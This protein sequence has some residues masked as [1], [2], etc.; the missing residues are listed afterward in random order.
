MAIGSSYEFWLADDA[1]A[2]LEFLEPRSWE[3]AL[4]VNGFGWFALTL[5]SS[6]DALLAPDYRVAIWRRPPG[7]TLGLEMVGLIR[8][9]DLQG[10]DNDE[11]TRVSGPDISELLDR[12][13]VAY[14]AASPQSDKTDFA[15]DMM[16]EVVGQN[17]GAGAIAARDIT[18]LGF[19]IAG[20]LGLGPSI[21]K[22]F[23]WRN[24]LR[25]L[26]DI[27]AA[28]KS[29]G[30]EVF[31]AI[32]PTTETMFQ[33]QTFTGQ[34]GA[35]RTQGGSGNPLTISEE[36][37]NLRDPRLRYDS[38]KERNY[39][40]TGGGGAEAE[41]EIVEVSDATRIA[42][43]QWNRREAFVHAV[44]AKTAGITAAGNAELAEG[45]PRTL[46]SGT[47]VDMPDSRYGID[48]RHGDQ[49]TAIYRGQ[50][51]DV[52]ARAVHVRVNEAGDETITAK[53]EYQE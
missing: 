4:I 26:R 30:T 24:M 49:M 21:T 45:R 31:F 23:A 40:Y 15:D 29:A 20:N 12:R 33:F 8:L 1:G 50:Q 22:A 7:G 18:A 36:W 5:D 6:T 37:G 42:T 13:I 25:V 38:I 46:F 28:S 51:F 48:W 27:S 52:I 41:R 53:L 9:P 10:F 39:I 32:V 11:L 47:L 17:L 14:A 44:N 34:P 35:D 43:S 16:K 3:Y 2:R 19:T